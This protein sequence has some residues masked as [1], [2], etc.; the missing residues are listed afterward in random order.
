MTRLSSWVLCSKW[1][2]PPKRFFGAFPKQFFTLVSQSPAV[3]WVNGCCFRK[4]SVEGSAN[5]FKTFVSQMAV[6]SKKFF[7]GFRQLCFTIHLPVS[8]WGQSCVN[9]CHVSRIQIQSTEN[10]PSCRC[11]WGVLWVYFLDSCC[12]CVSNES[13]YATHEAATWTLNHDWLCLRIGRHR[14]SLQQCWATGFNQMAGHILFCSSAINLTI[15]PVRKFPYQGFSKGF[16]IS[17]FRFFL[18]TTSSTQPSYYHPMFPGCS[19]R[20]NHGKTM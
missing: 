16:S 3:F 14:K 1:L 11:C 6:A 18:N 13:E 9:C 15:H 19:M 5:V 12:P 4:G 8:S 2:S 7:G 20:T 10:D 17:P